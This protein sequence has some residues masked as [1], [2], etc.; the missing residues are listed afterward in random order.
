M[1]VP[2]YTTHYH[3]ISEDIGNL[4]NIVSLK[5]GFN[6]LHTLP[7]EL[8]EM[9]DTLTALDVS[10][11]KISDYPANLYVCSHLVELNL[12]FNHLEKV[13]LSIGDLELLKVVREWE[14]GI[15]QLKELSNL[16]L[17]CVRGYSLFELLWM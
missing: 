12:S 6:Q 14:V 16:N 9:S 3:F 7:V 2:P 17:R 10:N 13:P 1:H 11:N 5:A 4:T 15:G 8:E